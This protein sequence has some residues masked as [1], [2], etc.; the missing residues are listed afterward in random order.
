MVYNYEAGKRIYYGLAKSVEIDFSRPDRKNVREGGLVKGAKI[1]IE[2]R[3]SVRVKGCKRGGR[4]WN[5][6]RNYTLDV[7]SGMSSTSSNQKI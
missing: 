4:S 7:G 1:G 5:F 3:N 6:S 2:E